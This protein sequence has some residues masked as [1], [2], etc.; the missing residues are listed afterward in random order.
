MN[1]AGRWVVHLEFLAASAEHTVF[2]EQTGNQLQGTHQGQFLSGDLR[3][4]VEGNVIRFR[5]SQKYEGSYVNYEFSGRIEGDVME[6]V[7]GDLSTI[8]PAEYG[9][10]RW[11]ARR[12]R[13]GEP[14]VNRGSPQKSD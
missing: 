3:G 11:S 1:V 9:Q 7:V 2:L 14:G 13:Y 8:T 4:K 10:A 5:S 6:G 12:H